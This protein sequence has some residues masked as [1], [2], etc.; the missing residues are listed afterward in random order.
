MALFLSELMRTGDAT[1]GLRAFLAKRA[2][3]WSHR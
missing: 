3:T 1:E 2:P